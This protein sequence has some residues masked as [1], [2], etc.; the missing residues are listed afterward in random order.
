MEIEKECKSRKGKE[1]E[2]REMKDTL[3]RRKKKRK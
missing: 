2:I 1:T 3:D